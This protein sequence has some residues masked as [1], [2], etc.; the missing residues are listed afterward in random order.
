ME[1][2]LMRDNSIKIV[3][4]WINPVFLS[5]TVDAN[6]NNTKTTEEYNKK[7]EEYIKNTCATTK[8]KK[9]VDKTTK[10]VGKKMDNNV[11]LMYEP[12]DN[13]IFSLWNPNN[14]HTYL[15]P[16][17]EE[18]SKTKF[19]NIQAKQERHPLQNKYITFI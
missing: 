15:E 13:G 14:M 10:F 7:V 1:L 8:I 5:T 3:D 18:K 6:N 19:N 11:A 17:L 4:G 16:I 2:D 12:N 9:Y